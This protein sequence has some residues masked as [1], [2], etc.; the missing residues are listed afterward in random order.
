MAISRRK[1]KSPE[2][3]RVAI[4]A[5]YSSE[6]Q[7][8]SSAD[9]QK[10]ICREYAEQ[11][12]WIVVEECIF[13][14]EAKSGQSVA[15]R[16]GLDKMMTLAQQD[17]PPFDGILVADTSRFGRKLT[18]TLHMSE[19]LEYYKVFLYFVENELDSRDRNFRKLFID[20]GQR[21]EEFVRFVARKVHNGQRE[22]ALNGHLPGGRVFGYD[23]VPVEHPTKK[24]RWN[25]PAVD[26]VR[27]I[28]NPI[29]A[30]I[31]RRIF[32]MYARG[33]GHRS[34]ART[35]NAE[36]VPSPLQGTNSPIKREW[37]AWSV[38]D[39][40]R[41][42]KYRGVHVW[43]KT[44]TVRN[45]LTKKKEQER[46]TETEWEYIDVP[47]W[48]IVSDDLWNAVQAEIKRRQGPSWWLEGGLNLTEASR[49]YLFSGLMSCAVCGGSIN[50]VGGK[51]DSARYGCVGHRY[52]GTCDNKL[53]ILKRVL[54][55]RLL[56][57]LATNL[58]DPAF[59][60]QLAQEFHCQLVTAWE[61]RARQ[62]TQLTS[63]APHLRERR[64]ELQGQGENIANAIAGSGT[65]KILS[66]RLQSIE[67]ELK[68]IEKMLAVS[69]EPEEHPVPIQAIEEFL[70]RK[71]T[72]IAALLEGDP[73]QTKLELRKRVATLVLEPKNTPDGPVY[74][75][76]G[77]IRLFAA[78]DDVEKGISSL[79]T[80]TLY[81]SLTIPFKAKIPA[82]HPKGQP[83]A[84]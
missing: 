74:E 39:I 36:R 25:R 32:E 22:R 48:R 8:S 51:G 3:V 65:S 31:V 69:E 13:S 80:P 75:V 71:T 63:S 82:R 52:R 7:N 16:D 1:Q 35:L 14:D 33:M 34:I 68:S 30:A 56:T 38:A 76:T 20:S 84:A 17:K 45:P 53:T 44:K 24:G 18:D 15:G 72:N 28:P 60:V 9:H 67:A 59:R 41:R 61:E 2:I 19:V 43:N 79:G 42:D 47:E 6:L 11:Q 10:R 57:G 54:E 40:L 55:T 58:Q 77:D 21:D 78:A 62:A 70:E 27:L 66:D 26:H 83:L 23:N 4:Y 37:N 64:R 46:R 5:R 73:E 29:Q 12:G 50:I 49:R 81:N